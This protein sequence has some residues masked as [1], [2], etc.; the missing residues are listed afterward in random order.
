VNSHDR[1]RVTKL[2]FNQSDINF[3]LEVGSKSVV[4]HRRILELKFSSGKKLSIRFDQGISYCKAA[5][6]A[7]SEMSIYNFNADDITQQNYLSVLDINIEG[8]EMPTRLFLKV[9]A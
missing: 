6:A 4:E 5:W 7:R 3:S 9:R 8:R 1:D 2:L